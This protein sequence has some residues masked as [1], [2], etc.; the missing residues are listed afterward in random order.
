[1][2]KWISLIVLLSFAGILFADSNT[3]IL[4]LS[5]M[6][7]DTP[8]NW[9]FKISGGRRA[10]Q[11]ST[12]PVP[13]NYELQGFGNY[14]YGLDK[15]PANE[16][17]FYRH[18]FVVPKSW[19]NKRIFI[20]FEG[21]MTD[22]EVKI[23]GRLAGPVHQGGFYRFQYDITRLIEPD[24]SNLLEVKVNNISADSTV[25]FAE[26]RADY[27]VFGGI[28]RPV[29]LKAVPQEYIDWTAIDAR[30]NGQFSMDVY[31]GFI[32]KANLVQAQIRRPDGTPLD[33]PFCAAIPKRQRKVTLRT[34]VHGQKNWTAET[35]NLYTVDINLLHGNQ[36]IHTIRKRFGFRTFEVVDG[37]GLFLNGKRII[38]KGCSRHSFWPTSG[39]ALNRNRCRDDILTIKKM[40]MN[41]VRMSHYPPDSYFLDLCDEL[42]LYVLD[43]LGGW[44][45]PAYDTAV[46]KKLLAEMVMRDVNHPSILFWDNGNEGGWNTDLDPV[47]S[48]Y[49]PQNRRVLH[50]G[51]VYDSVNARHYPVY[52][53]LVNRLEE[54]NILLPTE[55]LH[56]LY[57]GGLGSGMDDYWHLLWD[58]P[59]FGGMFFWV[60][61]DEGVVRTDSNCTIDTDGNHAPDGIL[62]PFHEKEASFFTIKEIWSPVY[63]ESDS[64]LPAKFDGR[65]QVENRYDFINLNRCQFEWR[66]VHFPNPAQTEV[67]PTV[68]W[69]GTFIGPNLPPHKKG[70][71]QIPLPATWRQADGLFLTAYDPNHKRLFTWRWKWTTPRQL[72]ERLFSNE[73]NIHRPDL[74]KTRFSL[75]ASAAGFTFS[76]DRHT[77]LLNQVKIGTHLLPFG[78]GPVLV[79]SDSGRFTQ[80]GSPKIR[81]RKRN[82]SL[83]LDVLNRA[84]FDT[85]QWTLYG[86]GWLKLHY[87]FTL[88]DSVK[89]LG[90]SFNFPENH[91][92]EMTWLGKG[93]YRVWKNR[94]KGQTISVWHNVYKKFQAGKG[95]DYPEFAGYY[96]DFNWVLFK[97]EDGPFCI[98]TDNDSLY[99]R[100]SSQKDGIGARHTKMTWPPGTV[101]F[102]NAIPPIGTKFH[103]PEELGPQGEPFIA[104]GTY[105]GSL[106]FYF[107]LPPAK[108]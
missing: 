66:L 33:E 100:V 21:S 31:L 57:D 89:F 60:F 29:Y 101:S 20:V 69:R 74:E 70:F 94:L 28:Y 81:I 11:W 55:I 86:S 45:R 56:G 17:G 10:N 93:P 106:Y 92:N 13:S 72:R 53:Q 49:D 58:K 9:D 64:S 43:E 19:K 99:F 82:R 91:L 98:A 102:L 34:H 4:Y 59:R 42:G 71:L 54:K 67:E 96:A 85:L 36:I 104:N 52:N 2:K 24:V 105:S 63:I 77:G 14:N 84:D 27:W 79:T 68:L 62:G 40:N 90:I 88:H 80:S 46:G 65:I 41:A 32:K 107:G 16:I 48:L 35:P 103:P 18:T 8:V 1:M 61:A 97:T 5:G 95:W 3:E 38:L 25:T 87:A 83:N 47:F 22:T 15:H 73:E 30:A 12:I 75:L 37:K 6:G 39:R 51:A 44:H 7:S 108:N 78:K 76:F 26:R 23:N 50:P